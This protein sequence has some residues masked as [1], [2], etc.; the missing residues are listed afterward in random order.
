MTL[1][2]EQP[3]FVQQAAHHSFLAVNKKAIDRWGDKWTDPSH[4]VTNGPFKL[5]VWRH[6]AEL[7]LTKWDEWRDADNVTL[8]R[9]NGKIITDG[10]TAEQSYEAGDIEVD[11][12]ASRR[13]TSTA[14]S[15]RRTTSSTTAS[16]PTT[17]AS[18]SRTSPT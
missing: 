6:D 5:A 12:T 18:T 16:A 3:W 15:P 11:T 10:T 4:I 2:S 1:T 14:G 7:D 9:I 17:T 8:T 13:R